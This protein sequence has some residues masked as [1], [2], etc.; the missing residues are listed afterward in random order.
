MRGTKQEVA[1]AGAAL[2]PLFRARPAAE[3]LTAQRAVRAIERIV[4]FKGIACADHV[5]TNSTFMRRAAIHL[6]D[7]PTAGWFDHWPKKELEE[8]AARHQIALS[9]WLAAS[10]RTPPRAMI[11]TAVRPAG[12]FMS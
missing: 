9:F 5:K 2:K 7:A 10:V 12:L 4:E 6:S 1:R 3:A 11:G 8:R